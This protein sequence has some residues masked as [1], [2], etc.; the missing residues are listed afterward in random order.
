MRTYAE[1]AG[2]DGAG[3]SKLEPASFVVVADDVAHKGVQ[4][5]CQGRLVTGFA[6]MMNLAQ[7]PRLSLL[8]NGGEVGHVGIFDKHPMQRIIV[9]RGLRLCYVQCVRSYEQL[10]A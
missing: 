6:V 8:Q 9:G 4:W 1:Q 3:H 7:K 10:S 5:T 2:N